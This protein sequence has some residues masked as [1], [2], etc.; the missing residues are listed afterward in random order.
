MSERY[1]K[2]FSLE[3]NLYI[4]GSPV[5]IAAGALL[6]D[7]QTGRILGQLKLQ[8]ISDQPI[9][10]ATV[11]LIPLDT[12]GNPLGEPVS[13]QY[14]DLKVTRDA[15]WGSQDPIRFSD[16]STRA[17]TASVKEV[18]FSDNSIWTAPNSAWKALPAKTTLETQLDD[19]ELATQYRM[20]FGMDCQYGYQTAEDLWYCPCGAVNHQG[21]RA[22][23][24]CQKDSNE[25]AGVDWD[26]LRKEA[27]E[28]VAKKRAEEEALAAEKKAKQ[29]RIQ[30][31]FQGRLFRRIAVVALILVVVIFAGVNYHQVQERKQAYM[32]FCDYIRE[33]GIED[34]E[35]LVSLKF[36]LSSG[37]GEWKSYQD[38]SS[39]PKILCTFNQFAGGDLTAVLDPGSNTVSLE[40]TT[41]PAESD[42][43]AWTFEYDIPYDI[44]K[45]W[46][47]SA[48]FDADSYSEGKTILPDEWSDASGESSFSANS[49]EE[50]WGEVL[51]HKFSEM[52]SCLDESL[53]EYGLGISVA[54]L[55]FTSY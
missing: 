37:Y 38:P 34:G 50:N 23:H 21:E 5:L 49:W 16:P 41:S 12:V 1:L 36:D 19:F 42:S 52:L 33:N 48:N 29:E 27:A 18:I 40:L 8:N 24:S 26:L 15:Y 2:L 7:T 47:I 25:L 4:P 6:K 30:N 17:Y 9:K 31:F 55:G 44:T 51:S 53:Q 39:E 45:N 20:H 11:A 3:E 28:R 46:V 54:D 43:Y 14:L 10:A 35:Y 32:V 13:Y 22:C